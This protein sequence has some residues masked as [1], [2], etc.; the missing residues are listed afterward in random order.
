MTQTSTL[1]LCLEQDLRPNYD[2][3]RNKCPGQSL[4]ED[5]YE[6]LMGFSCQ[7]SDLC[8]VI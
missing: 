1:N 6:C 7:A 4:S 5:I 8:G 2:V 3:C